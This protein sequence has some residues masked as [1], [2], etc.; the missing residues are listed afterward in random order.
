MITLIVQD[1]TGAAVVVGVAGV[2]TAVN[3][4]TQRARRLGE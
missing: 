4:S 3:A 1:N 2:I